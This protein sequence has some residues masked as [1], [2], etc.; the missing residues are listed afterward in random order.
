MEPL[1]KI[2]SGN[3]KRFLAV[4]NAD[5]ES[6]NRKAFSSFLAEYRELL[7]AFEDKFRCPDIYGRI[8]ELIDY[9]AE[10]SDEDFQR[11]KEDFY[12]IQDPSREKLLDMLG[13]VE[14]A[15][16]YPLDMEV[17]VKQEI[18][19]N[20]QDD[21]FA[22]KP[23]PLLLPETID[24]EKDKKVLESIFVTILTEYNLK[25]SRLY[26]CE[27]LKCGSIF[28]RHTEGTRYCSPRC[29]NAELQATKRAKDKAEKE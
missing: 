23:V 6:M 21:I 1:K 11:A 17:S 24:V 13:D 10:C 16:K 5:I 7:L 14:S 27:R 2:R 8:G 9:L 15:G 20:L 26:R 28:F 18:V 3:L 4:V 12:R 25:P 29:S 19:L 22:L